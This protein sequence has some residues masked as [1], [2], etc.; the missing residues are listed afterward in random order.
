MYYVQENLLHL[1]ARQMAEIQLMDKIESFGKVWELH[2]LWDFQLT[3]PFLQ[4]ECGKLFAGWT[5]EAYKKVV[6]KSTALQ[7]IQSENKKLKDEKRILVSGYDKLNKDI[8]LTEKEFDLLLR[9]QVTVAE[10][11]VYEKNCF[12]L[13]MFH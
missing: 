4:K 3:F 13:S 12:C 9:I 1:K 2:S 10:L 8:L 5:R 6:E 11:V 7:P